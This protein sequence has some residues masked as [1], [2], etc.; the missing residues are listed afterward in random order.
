MLV[1]RRSHWQ[2]ESLLGKRLFYCDILSCFSPASNHA[3]SSTLAVQ[4]LSCFNVHVPPNGHDVV[5][6]LVETRLGLP[7]PTASGIYKAIE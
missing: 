4:D 2:E 1:D 5:G 3:L 6:V 7:Q